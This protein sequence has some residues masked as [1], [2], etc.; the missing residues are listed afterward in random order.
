MTD[1]GI[2]AREAARPGDESQGE[3]DV[4]LLD[5]VLVLARQKRLLLGLPFV[6]AVI[7]AI[8]V[9]MLPKSYTATARVLPPQQTQP[10][11]TAL[12]SQ[13]GGL[14]AVAGG[15]SLGLKNPSDIF[16]AMLKSRTVADA[17]IE[18]FDLARVYDEKLLTDMREK[19]ADRTE[20]TSGRDGVIKI[21]VE[22]RDPKRAA[23]MAN[24]YVAQLERLTFN[25]A[26][27]EGGQR[28]LFFE[29]QL[30]KAKTDLGNAEI[31]L[32]RF[33]EKNGI[34]LPE[35]Q[36][37]ATVAVAAGL[38]AQVTAKEVQISALR[39]FATD[40]NPDLV[41]TE[42]E[43]SSL[44]GQLAK[45][46]RDS[47]KSRGDVLVSIG[48]APEVAVEYVQRYRDM[49][50]FETLYEVLAKQYE[51]AR[52]DEARGATV[53]QVL[54]RAVEPDKKS[55]PKR[56]LIVL[57]TAFSALFVALVAAFFVEAIRNA[58]Q[59]PGT[60]M[61]LESLRRSLTFR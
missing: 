5:V 7:A 2:P 36:A 34:I 6:A 56:T 30:I 4:S 35:A 57:I 27:T 39:A 14:A 51:L 32:Q 13:L 10:S 16:V 55:G 52:I 9:L 29:K 54:D 47:G 15:A 37:N 21:E 58:K 38:R 33:Q 19:L 12:L 40:S 31:A 53:I 3:E 22:D 41:R 20:V 28:R 1:R 45:M 25:L 23:A 43:L 46:E 42:Q 26:I 61:K 50:Y 48:R 24:E 11:A 60:R 44:R 18:K 59:E 8:V 49:K 17:V